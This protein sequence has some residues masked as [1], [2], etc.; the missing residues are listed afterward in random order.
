[1]LGRVWDLSTECSV[2]RRSSDCLCDSHLHAYA[3]VQPT[4]TASPT[5]T[6]TGPTRT[7]TA[8]PPPAR[9][10]GLA[11]PILDVSG[12]NGERVTV[13]AYLVGSG[14]KVGG[15][16]FDLL[17]LQA[18]VAPV[19]VSEQ[20]AD[21]VLQ[22]AFL[23]THRLPLVAPPITRSLDSTGCRCWWRTAT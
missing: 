10:P 12:S 1:M 18:A 13:E 7:P 11:V 14:G 5:R 4:R 17:L 2:S 15:L 9:I 3:G 20:S 16:E 19:A 22:A 8:A 21:S 6:P 23:S